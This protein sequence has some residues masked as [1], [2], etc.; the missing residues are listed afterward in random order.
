M[1]ER[2]NFLSLLIN[3]CKFSPLKYLGYTVC[4]LACVGN[5]LHLISSHNEYNN[6]NVL[7]LVNRKESIGNH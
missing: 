4:I 6:S 1:Q 2:L 3:P 5:H 7:H